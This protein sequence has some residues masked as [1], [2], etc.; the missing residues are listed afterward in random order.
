VGND[1]IKENTCCSVSDVIE[2]RHGFIPLGEVIDYNDDVFVSIVGWR[3]A[4]HK[5][6]APFAEGANGDD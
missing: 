1:V 3:V 5:V 2:S 4:S 6:Y